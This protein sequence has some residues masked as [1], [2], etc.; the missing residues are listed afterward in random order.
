MKTKVA[1]RVRYLTD[2]QIRLEK[3]IKMKSLGS[4]RQDV[5]WL[6]VNRPSIT[7]QAATEELGKSPA[8]VSSILAASARL[9]P[10]LVDIDK[11]KKP[12]V[13]KLAPK[14]GEE[15]TFDEVYDLVKKRESEMRIAKRQGKRAP[16][17]PDSAI[18]TEKVVEVKPGPP[19]PGVAYHVIVDINF[20]I[21][22]GRRKD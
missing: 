1:K 3:G 7:A 5:I 21:N 8:S 9:I 22:L 2:E 18:E 19:L 16:T 4:I 11:T 17:V 12:F 20:N 13:Y 10:D 14:D 6:L 15:Y